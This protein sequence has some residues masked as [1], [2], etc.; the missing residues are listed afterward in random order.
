MSCA[1]DP[2]RCATPIAIAAGLALLPRS[3]GGFAQW[4]RHLLAA[5]GREP[6]LSHWRAR[7]PG[8]LGLMLVEMSAYVLDVTSFY[9]ELVANESYLGTASLPDARRRHVALLG[10]L[11]RP[12]MGSAAWLAAEADGT[13]LLSLPAGS[14]V[15]SGAFKSPAGA[16]Q[17]QVFET[18]ADALIEPRVNRL[19]VAR[20]PASSLPSPFDHIQVRA[21]SVRAR[22]DMPLVVDMNGT[23]AAT[24]L[25]SQQPLHLRSR[26]AASRLSFAGTLTPPAGASYA[27]TR[28]LTPGARCGAWKL[29]PGTGELAVLDSSS[30]SLDARVAIHIGDIVALSVGSSTV[31]RRVSGVSETA[32]TLLGPLTSDIKDAAN[33]IKGHLT[34]PAIQLLVTRLSFDAALPFAA[35]DAA[36][37]SLHYA[38][39]EAATPQAPLADT[40][41]QADNAPL[42]DCF[43][44]PR[45]PVSQ[46]LLTDVHGEAVSA[47]GV[48][49]TAAQRFTPD[50]SPPWGRELTAPVN[51]YGN[52]IAVTRGETVHGEVLGI[53]DGAQALQSFRLKKKPL[54]YLSAGNAAGRRSTLSVWVGQVRWQEV[55]SFYGVA[56]DARVYTVRHNDAGE[57]DI[58]FGG[59]ARL[60]TGAR[61]LANYRWG[62]GAAVPPADSIKQLAKPIPGLRRLFNAVPAYGGADA[63]SPA[64]LAVRGP[65][66][67]LLLGRAISLADFEAAAAQQNG[68]RA[69]RASWRWDAQGLGPA[70]IV[71]VI[72]DPGVVPTVQAALRALAEDGAPLSVQAASA[73]SAR[74]DVDVSIAADQDPDAVIT[75]IA[76][77]LWAPVGLPGSGGLLRAERLG[78]DG[79]LFASAVV[80]CVMAVPGVTG[81]NALRLD[82]SDFTDIGRRPAAGAYFAF[83]AGGVYINGRAA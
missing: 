68:V 66:S 70:V 58:Q 23:L 71:A 30:V 40:L 72:A 35:S 48:L 10:H 59:G 34:S 56:S 79:V 6:G 17:P 31:A 64:E 22:A 3:P 15:R 44:A 24:R 1:C 25:A 14:A 81:L 18:E 36:H 19:A 20:V 61:V 60:P 12:A 21:G 54:T 69:A 77:A 9:D 39:V 62:A 76:A 73:Q 53:G 75:A 2:E 83:E 63:E 55:E 57:T 29:T 38:M 52:V 50:A 5:I 49:D 27:T 32:Y 67:A 4:R 43:D 51:L 46:V 42:P 82:A 13:R 65:Q 7:E 28:L 11:P 37:L 8:D 33:A 26:Q 74:L 78:P 47:H 45:T 16:E 80:A 41:T